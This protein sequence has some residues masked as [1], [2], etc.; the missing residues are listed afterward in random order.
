MNESAKTRPRQPSLNLLGGFHHAAPDA[1]GG[2][3]PVN[4]VAVAIAAVRA[5]GFLR[6][7]VVLDLDAHPP[8]GLALCL[9]DDASRYVVALEARRRRPVIRHVR[10]LARGVQPARVF[11]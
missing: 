4:D 2:F 11:D 3:C 5:E 8:D 6:R 10:D 1:A 9:L 7:V